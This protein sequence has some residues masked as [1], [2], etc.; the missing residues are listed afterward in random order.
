MKII[1]EVYAEE[2]GEGCKAQAFQFSLGFKKPQMKLFDGPK[3]N[4][5]PQIIIKWNILCVPALSPQVFTTSF[6]I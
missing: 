3:V 6:N 2:N 4:C 1:L 5:K